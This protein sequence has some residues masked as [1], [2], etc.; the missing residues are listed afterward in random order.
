[1][2]LRPSRKPAW[3]MPQRWLPPA[4]ATATPSWHWEAVAHLWRSSASSVA[5]NRAR[6][7]CYATVGWQPKCCARLI[8]PPVWR[9]TLTGEGRGVYSSGTYA[10]ASISTSISGSIS[11]LTSTMVAAGR[12]VPKNSPCALPTCSQCWMLTTYMRVRT[13]W[14][15]VAPAWASAVSMVRRAWTVCAY[16]SPTPTMPVGV[17]AVV[18]ATCTYGPTRTAREYP[19]RGSHGPPLEMFRRCAAICVLLKDHALKQSEA[20]FLVGSPH[21][22]QDI[23]NFANG[24]VSM[25]GVYNGWHDIHI[26][27]RHAF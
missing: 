17:M 12:I 9:G 14:A 2:P 10:S 26:A 18:P 23:S 4:G 22:P 5:A 27:L 11:P 3:T 1:M 24:A 8:T 7:P 13:T 20:L 6:R 15:S 16:G 25:Y 21:S 19:T